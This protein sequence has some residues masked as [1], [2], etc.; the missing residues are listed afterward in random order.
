MAG[1]HGTVGIGV[2]PSSNDRPG[3][4]ELKLDHSEPLAI[5]GRVL[6]TGRHCGREATMFESSCASVA[7]VGWW[8][9]VRCV[10]VAL[11]RRS[12]GESRAALC[13]SISAADLGRC[14]EP[15]MVNEQRK[16]LPGCHGVFYG[17]RGGMKSSSGSF[18][19]SLARKLRGETVSFR[20]KI[21]GTTKNS[22]PDCSITNA[23]IK[24][25]LS[26]ILLT[27]LP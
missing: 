24:R 15:F 5:R 13:S 19:S 11:G 26:L 1:M 7:D 23:S 3:S 14:N 18:Q 21:T 10:A 9:W 27:L 2:S 20:S 22:K 6:G 25:L 17:I 8:L 12:E 16:A 4:L